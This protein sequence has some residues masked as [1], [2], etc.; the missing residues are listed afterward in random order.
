MVL[1]KKDINKTLIFILSSHFV[2]WILIPSLSNNNL[3]L[4][5]IEAIT[6][7]NGFPLGFH[8]HPPLSAWFP[9]FIFQIFGSQDWSYYLLSQIF[10]VLSFF[11][12]FKFS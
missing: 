9:E 2:I 3:P 6:W 12:I 8:K 7:G 1:K 4:D 5:V 10:V 11:I